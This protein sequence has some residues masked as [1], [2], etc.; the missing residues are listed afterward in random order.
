MGVL[1]GALGAVGKVVAGI[2]AAASVAG[3]VSSIN[4]QRRA[5]STQRRQQALQRRRSIRQNIRQ[6][7]IVRAQAV[8]G[9]VGAGSAFGSG[10]SGGIGANESRLGEAIGYS[11]QQSGLSGIITNANARANTGSNIAGLGGSLFRMGGGFGA[12]IQPEQQE[13][14]LTRG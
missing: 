12:F 13:V 10:F 7:Q 4:A 8:A 6:A 14:D 3:T 11:A 5:S 9:A 2:G 1:V